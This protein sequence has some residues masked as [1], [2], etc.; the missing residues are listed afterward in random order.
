M[1]FIV[2]DTNA[3]EDAVRI[4]HLDGFGVLVGLTKEELDAVAV[5]VPVTEPDANAVRVAVYDAQAGFIFVSVNSAAVILCLESS[6]DFSTSTYSWSSF[7]RSC[8]FK[9][10]GDVIPNASFSSSFSFVDCDCV[11]DLMFLSL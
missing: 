10:N 4:T 6:L 7:L 9:P 3:G 1:F 2:F 5:F 11:C 8:I